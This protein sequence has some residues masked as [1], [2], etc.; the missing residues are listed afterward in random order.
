MKAHN[1]LENNTSMDFKAFEVPTTPLLHVI[2]EK[3]VKKPT[4]NLRWQTIILHDHE[5]A[6][7]NILNVVSSISSSRT[8]DSTAD[9]RMDKSFILT[10]FAGDSQSRTGKNNL[11]LEPSYFLFITHKMLQNP[12]CFFFSENSLV[13]IIHS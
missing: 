2:N 4:V 5:L 6:E 12:F 1:A 11:F 8:R 13:I 10:S 3:K 9:V 7:H